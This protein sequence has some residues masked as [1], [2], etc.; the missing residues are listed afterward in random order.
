[1][2][3][4]DQEKNNRFYEHNNHLFYYDH[5]CLAYLGEKKETPYYQNESI[6]TYKTGALFTDYSSCETISQMIFFGND[7]VELFSIVPRKMPYDVHLGKSNIEYVNAIVFDSGVLVSL[8]NKDKQSK[9]AYYFYDKTMISS[10]DFENLINKVK[11]LT[12]P[13]TYSE[14]LLKHLGQSQKNLPPREL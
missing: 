6:K 3:I 14:L 5:E 11:T 7:G 8:S 4:L 9:Y 2:E 13:K 10:Y 12:E 1:M